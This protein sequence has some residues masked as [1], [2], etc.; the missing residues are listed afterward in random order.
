[1]KKKRFHRS[2][3]LGLVLHGNKLW[4]SEWLSVALVTA[5]LAAFISVSAVILRNN[6]RI[7]RL[8][9]Q[10]ALL[11]TEKV[12]LTHQ[13]AELRGRA[14]IAAALEHLIGSMVPQ[15]TVVELLDLVYHNSLRYG[16]DPLLVLAVIH[17]ESV[18][19]PWAL[20]QFRDGRE[21]GAVGL[22]QLKLET[23]QLVARNFGI[24]VGRK[25][26]LY[27]PEINIPLGIA[28]LTQ[29]ISQFKDFKLALMAYNEGPGAVMKNLRESQ[30]LSMKY[31]RKVLKSYYRFKALTGDP[32]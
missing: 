18:F 12:E 4:L 24:T 31:Y 5:L 3:A 8:G 30:P 25:E 13:L 21:S 22:M 10:V 26:D 32:Q 16:Y 7:D 19:N 27:E 23:A 20:G 15:E 1:V 29:L 6:G 17:V 28:Y 11:K 9:R 14:R 2:L